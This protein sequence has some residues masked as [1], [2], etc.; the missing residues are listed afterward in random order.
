[1][2]STI[3]S[4]DKDGAARHLAGGMCNIYFGITSGV[5]DEPGEGGVIWVNSCWVCAAGLSEPLPYYS[6]FCGQL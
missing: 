6:L 5:Q 4:C 2:W 3:V 1:M